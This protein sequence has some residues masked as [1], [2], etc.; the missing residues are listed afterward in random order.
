MTDYC[1]DEKGVEIGNKDKVREYNNQY[2]HN[3]PNIKNWRLK[4]KSKLSDYYRHNILTVNGKRIVV[5]KRKFE[6]Y[7]ELC[8]EIVSNNFKFPHWHHWNDDKPE[9]G[10]WLCPACH[11]IAEAVEHDPKLVLMKEYKL[12]RGIE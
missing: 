6:G 1:T 12:K 3:K 10:M 9:E 11:R 5:R 8:K 7:C 2:Y 4:N